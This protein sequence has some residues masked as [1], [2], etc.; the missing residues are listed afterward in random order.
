MDGYEATRV[1]RSD[2][3][4]KKLPIIAMTA[5]AMA[6]DRETCLKAGMND[7]IAKPIDSDD[8][9]A[10]VAQWIRP[11]AMGIRGKATESAVARS[12]GEMEL[13]DTIPG[14]DVQSA[15]KRLGG[16][17]KLLKKLLKTFAANNEDVVDQIRQALDADD[18]GEAQQRAHALKGVSG[19]ISA[20]DLHRAATK[21]D[22]ALKKNERE[23]AQRLLAQVRDSLDVVIR[24][25]NS[26]D[27]PD[28]Q[29]ELKGIRISEDSYS[30]PIE[31]IEPAIRELAGMLK[32]FDP[33]AV[34]LFHT[35]RPKLDVAGIDE[36][37]AELE[38]FVDMYDFGTSLGV[39]KRMARKLG[40]SLN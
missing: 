9:L 23:D 19:N 40:I 24:E 7:H 37:A 17:R 26:L 5:H 39:L 1:I 10:V 21:L 28:E 29:D 15:L 14:I 18:I 25:V 38:K 13:P 34:D 30:R 31:P 16:N 6:G 35:M 27:L 12:D 33:N 32:A 2:D 3:R 36:D 20:V 4:F 11:D 22:R 8:L